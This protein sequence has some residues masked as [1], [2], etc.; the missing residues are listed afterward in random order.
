MAGV[1]NSG[2]L[3]VLLDS[4]GVRMLLLSVVSVILRL[5][6]VIPPTITLCRIQA[7]HIGTVGIVALFTHA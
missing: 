4:D 6:P 5:I 3:V 2:L 7:G 1:A